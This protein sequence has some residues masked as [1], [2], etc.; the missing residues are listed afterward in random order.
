MQKQP[1][2]FTLIELLVVISIISILIAIL[3]PALAKARL[4]AQAIKCG[5]AVKQMGMAIEVYTHDFKGYMP[6]GKATHDSTTY[7]WSNTLHI[8]KLLP[9]LNIFLCPTDNNP[10]LVFGA[11][12][13][14]YGGNTYSLKDD[15]K[16]FVQALKP[17]EL[18]LVADTNYDG[19]NNSYQ[20]GSASTTRWI[21]NSLRTRRHSDGGNTL[22]ADQHVSLN[23]YETFVE[24]LAQ[25]NWYDKGFD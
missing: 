4:S 25:G 18:I 24:S 2:G 15:R 1:N 19:S 7:V 9:D 8:L 17:S 14:S 22:F 11:Y 12:K 20:I 21:L 5:T 23:P 10:R 13:S 6:A 3:L 16:T